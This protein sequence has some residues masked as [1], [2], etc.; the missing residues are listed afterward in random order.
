MFWGPICSDGLLQGPQGHKVSRAGQP[1]SRTSF[2]SICG[3]ATGSPFPIPI[4]QQQRLEARPAL[5]ASGGLAVTSIVWTPS[6]AYPLPPS[7]QCF[8]VPLEA[9]QDAR[10]RIQNQVWREEG[11]ER[12]AGAAEDQALSG[13]ENTGR[14]SI[15]RRE[16]PHQME[17]TGTQRHCTELGCPEAHTA[18]PY[19]TGPLPGPDAKSIPGAP[20]PPNPKQSLTDGSTPPGRGSLHS[21]ELS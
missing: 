1:G 16:S 21:P 20:S 9:L 19:A 4:S 3:P 5:K 2:K 10:I 13:W 12:G 7:P 11:V 18:H 8:L 15:H 14:F 17:A 6:D